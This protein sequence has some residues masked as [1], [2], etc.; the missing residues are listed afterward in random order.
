MW[1]EPLHNSVKTH[2]CFVLGGESA[3]SWY[4]FQNQSECGSWRFGK[5]LRDPPLSTAILELLCYRG[6][7]IGR[8]HCILFFFCRSKTVQSLLHLFPLHDLKKP[9]L[10]AV[11]SAATP[12]SCFTIKCVLCCPLSVL[13]S[14]KAMSDPGYFL[15]IVIPI[16]TGAPHCWEEC[17]A[18]VS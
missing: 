12:Y 4:S 6:R 11:W 8:L 10:P 18:C 2:D 14:R 7:G 13:L 16:S 15:I 5:N 3:E 1:K 17:L 9:L